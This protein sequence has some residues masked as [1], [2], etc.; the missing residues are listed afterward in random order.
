MLAGEPPYS[1]PTAQAIVAKRFREPVPRIST[2]RETAPPA[3]EAA[4]LRVLAKS[5]V[6]RFANGTELLEAL[7]SAG[8][9]PGAPG[10]GVGDRRRLVG[11]VRHRR[12]RFCHSRT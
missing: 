8:S 3:L 5:P 1:G 6:D 9:E 11:P 4:L 12:S 10:A 7:Q 2:L